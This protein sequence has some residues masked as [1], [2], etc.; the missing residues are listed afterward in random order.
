MMGGAEY[1]LSKL[2]ATIFFVRV[3]ERADWEKVERMTRAGGVD[4][5]LLYGAVN[6][7]VANRL[8]TAPLNGVP[9]V[10]LG[11]HRCTQ[12]VHCVNV[13]NSAV[14]RLAAHHLASLGHRRIGFMGGTMHHAYQK[15]TLKGFRA[16]VREL[17]LDDHERLITDHSSWGQPG[18]K[19]T[20]EWLRNAGPTAL[21]LPD[22]EWTAGTWRFLK[23][24]QIEVPKDISLLGCGKGSG[25]VL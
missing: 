20:I 12:S 3:S 17:G 4:G 5:W 14:G 16:A 6:D 15:Q 21:F 23:Q 18:R 8:K 22:F 19:S 9:F 2:H 13:D 7:E 25:N 11:D 24:F 1:E 10:V